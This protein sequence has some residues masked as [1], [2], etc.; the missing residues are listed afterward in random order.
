MPQPAAGKLILS[1]YY[2]GGQRER[3]FGIGYAQSTARA[4]DLMVTHT[5]AVPTGDDP[6][7]LVQVAISSESRRGRLTWSE[8]WGSLMVHLD[9]AWSHA[10]NRSTFT[11]THY[12]STWLT[13]E[14]PH[15]QH[16]LHSRKW[17]GLTEEETEHLAA[18][19]DN[20]TPKNGSMWDEAPPSPFLAAVPCQGGNTANATTMLANDAA[21]YFSSG[22]AAKPSYEHKLQFNQTVPERDAALIAATS[23]DLRPGMIT[24]ICYVY[25]YVPFNASSA[26]QQR[27]TVAKLI[28]TY[29]PILNSPEGIA[30]TVSKA[31]K[32]LLPQASMPSRPWLGDEMLWHAYYL[33]GGVSFDSFYNEYIVDQGTAYRYDFGFQGAARDPLQHML[34][35]IEMAPHIAKSVLRYTFKEMMPTF[36]SLDASK[37]SSLPYAMEGRGLVDNGGGG[38]KADPQA[39]KYFPDDL[40]CYLLFAVA[41]YLLATKDFGFLKE[42][43]AF[44]NS[45]RTQTVLEAIQRSVTFITEEI[46]LGEHDLMRMLS[47]DWDD[48]YSAKNLVPAQAYNVSESVLTAGLATVA[49]PKIAEVLE[50]L[51]QNGNAAAAQSAASARKF[52]E[53]NRIAIK[54]AAW[55]GQWLR[56][57]WLDN[58]T[59][60]VGDIAAKTPGIPRLG[61]EGVFSAQHGW[62][63]SGGVFEGDEAALNKSLRSLL[64]HCR[65]NS[66]PY[67]FQYICGPLEKPGSGQQRRRMQFSDAPG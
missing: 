45:D 2:D 57:A 9:P 32:A 53:Q 25:G 17:S 60:W 39:Q 49:L 47:S 37:I 61:Y 29:T 7:V 22:T 48:G 20:P 10:A 51:E 1:S 54:A 67:G 34:P 50:T 33:R 27:E 28:A 42:S 35:L 64:T 38:W 52:A 43:T 55:N 44:W 4:D 63:Y 18:G 16:V 46:G 24:R 5:V 21:S 13:A 12:Q 65:T 58:E 56:R 6:V 31:W 3:Q 8:V 11:A 15:S 36:N 40:D 62:A 23:F 41:E 26:N 14:A 19:Y 59:G 30:A 66:T